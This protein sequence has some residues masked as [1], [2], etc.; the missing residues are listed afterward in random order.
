MPDHVCIC[1]LRG[2]NVGGANKLPMALFR[3][4]LA[5]L[6]CEDIATY[7]Q[8]GNA[9]FRTVRSDLAALAG[10]I[11]AAIE[12]AAGVHPQVLVLTAA[13]LEQAVAGNPYKA[14]EAEPKSLH[15]SFLDSVPP[16]P[17][18]AGMEALR[19][20]GERFCLDGAVSYLHAPDGIG[21]SKLAARGEKLIGVPATARNWRTVTAL[22]DMARALDG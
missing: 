7:I 4:V 9:V 1:L 22:L 16:A 21:R 14:A 2:I 20:P 10:D 6:G 3:D 17:D 15:V 8:S 11:G 19:A 12:A 18:L 5:G 13:A